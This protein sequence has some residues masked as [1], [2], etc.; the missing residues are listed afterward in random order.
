MF[1]RVLS[2]LD[3]RDNAPSTAATL[4]RFLHD[5]IAIDYTL[6]RS[7]RRRSITL[8]VDENGL[9][10]GA[11]SRASQSRVEALL[12]RH[13]N[14]IARKLAEW[15]ARRPPPFAWEPG[16]AIM[17]LGTPLV[18][19][20]DH[21]ITA[22]TRVGDHLCVV[23]GAAD[24]V[25]LKEQVTAWLRETAQVWFEQRAAHFSTVLDVRMPRIRLS[26][27][28]TRWGSCHPDGRVH[29]NWRLIQA[30]PAMIDYVV[31]HELA[32]LHEANH[33]PRF[34]R[35]VELV[36]PDYKERRQ[37]LRRESHHYLLA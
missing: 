18:L 9:R 5:G 27:A 3:M 10:V 19:T 34:W 25:A 6:K 31:V 21:S 33:S 7:T 32:H 28:K 22:T 37:A 35:R 24:P 36:M 4:E 20:P 26:N 2:L 1:K 13:A 29:L 16:A 30:P 11:P 8:T 17:T 23:A 14:W 12:I 15:N